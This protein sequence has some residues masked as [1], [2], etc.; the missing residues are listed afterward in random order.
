MKLRLWLCLRFALSVAAALL[1]LMPLVVLG[2]RQTGQIDWRLY[3]SPEFSDLPDMVFHA[4]RLGAIVLGLALFSLVRPSRAR[5]FAVSC[6]LVPTAFLFVT[7]PALHFFVHR[8]LLFITPFSCLG[9]A[10]VAD[11][12]AQTSLL[13]RHALLAALPSLVLLGLPFAKDGRRAHAAAR[14]PLPIR[15]RNF[16][17]LAAANELR[18]HALPNDAVAFGGRGL[19]DDWVRLALRYE[20]RNERHPRDVFML[21]SPAETGQFNAEECS[22]QAQCVEQLTGVSRVWLITTDMRDWFGS[23]APEKAL[24]LE[25]TFTPGY[26]ATFQNLRVA[27]LTRTTAQAAAP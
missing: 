4:R 20:L 10:L 26:N 14:A 5:W 23:M 12:L 24:A 18:A 27:L 11:D 6:A 7:Q 13:R 8:Y 21:H 3:L 15:W 16:A 22:T 17:Y 9:A 2:S 19:T 25:N 1:L